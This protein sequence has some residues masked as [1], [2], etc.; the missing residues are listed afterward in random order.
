[1]NAGNYCSYKRACTFRHFSLS[2]FENGH[3]STVDTFVN[4]LLSI[5]HLRYL[6]A[7]I[8]VDAV[9]K[10]LELLSMHE[11]AQRCLERS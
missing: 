6:S 7:C 5:V 8:L 3:T 1:M 2:V 10:S 4:N 11:D 9:A